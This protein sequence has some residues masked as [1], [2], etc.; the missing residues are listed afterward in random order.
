[1]ANHKFLVI[2]LGSMGKRRIRCLKALGYSDITGFDTSIE[3]R[4][5]AAEKYGIPVIDSLDKT[6]LPD[7]SAMI[8]STPPDHHRQYTEL[9]VLNNIPVFTEA[10]VIA[11]HVREIIRM[12]PPGAY[13]A[14]SCTFRFHPVI[15][16]ISQIA[17]SAKYGKITNFSYH[18]GNF[19]PDWHPWEK[20]GD[21]YASNR[22]T[23]GAREIVAFELTW[24]TDLL[25]FPDDIKGYFLKTGNVE[26]EI[27]DTY[28]IALR[29]NDMAGVLVVDVVSRYATRQLV[30]NFE[31]AQV[32]WNWEDGYFRI[33]ETDTGRWKDSARVSGQAAE[34]YNRNIIEEMYIDEI[35][36]FIDGIG[37]RNAY[38]NTVEDDLLVLELLEKT[39]NSDGGFNR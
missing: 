35:K 37:D 22:V 33:Y 15:R 10:S 4:E 32:R 30:L 1:M 12:K 24:L 36:A 8:V 5:E 14:P 38:P 2:G 29:Y 19:L 23:G 21:F 7:V 17:R 9:A 39:E 3:R 18:S 28:C 13:I 31:Q 6:D 20:V 25:G 16:E 34:G 26:A 11:D 27:E